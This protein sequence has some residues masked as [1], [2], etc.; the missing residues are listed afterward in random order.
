[1]A[2]VEPASTLFFIQRGKKALLKN[3]E[4]L[5]RRVVELET[6]NAQLKQNLLGS[7]DLFN[8]IFHASSNVMA[9]HTIQEG[10]F[11]DLNEACAKLGGFKR[12]ELIGHRMEEWDLLQDE[13]LKEI[14]AQK[15][16]DEGRI[17][18]VESKI[19]TKDG[20][21]RT[22]LFSADPVT[23]NSE[24]CLL[25]I[26]IDITERE[27]EASALRQSEEK[28]RSLVENSLQG[29][30]II[31]DSL[32]VFC[33]GNF[34][35]MLGCTVEEAL[36]L[37]AEQ[38]DALVFPDDSEAI[39][40]RHQDQLDGKPV[41]ARYEFRGF[42]LDGSMIWLEAYTSVIEFGGRP[43]IQSVYMDI[44]ER[45]NAENA[46]RESEERFRLLAETIDEIF[47]IFDMGGKGIAYLSPAY[48]RLWGYPRELVLMR[49]DPFMMEMVHVEDRDTVIANR[50]C[51]LSGR[52]VSFEYR[53]IRP[54]GSVRNMW[55]RAYPILDKGGNVFR[56]IGVGQDVTEWR[57][58]E[59]ALKEAK[60]YL[61]QIINC[62]GDPIFV[63]DREHRFV[64]V[65]DAICAFTGMKR[66]EM[67][68]HAG[69]PPEIEASLWRQEEHVFETRQETSTEDVFTDVQGNP[70]T[71]MTKKT[72]LTDKSGHEQIVGVLRDITEH[73]RLEAQFLQSQKMEAV[74]VLAGGVAHDFNNLLNV[75]NGYTELI[76]DGLAQGDPLRE[77][78]N[79]IRDAGQRA[80]ALT[81]Q[82]LD[83]GRKQL[84][85]PEIFDLNRVLSEMSA[86][87]RR[88]IGED[89]E[90]LFHPQSTPATIHADPAK[91]Q[92]VVMNLVIN[93]RDAMP[94][95]GK[96]TIETASVNFESGYISRHSVAKP[97]H[98]IMLA[99]SDTGAGMD[100]AIQAHVFEPFFTTKAKGKGTG[101]GLS[102]VYGIVKQSGGFI[103]VY[104]EPGKGTT[105]KTYFPKSEIMTAAPQTEAKP[106]IE[107]TGLETV[108]L[109]EDEAAVRSLTSRILRDRGYNVLEAADGME[110]LNISQEY[111]SEIHMV[112]TDVVMPGMGGKALVSRI[113]ELRPGVKTLFISGYTDNAIS[114]HGILDSGVAFLQKP[115]TLDGLVRKVR[116]VLDS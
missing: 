53:I 25:G 112:L 26:S 114:H 39:R 66:D 94:D 97:G 20:D 48:D 32:L 5:N 82:L 15:L 105:I 10:R 24:P 21:V 46:L 42:K 101:L 77:E 86:M 54:D 50:E 47:W 110:A 104:S 38:L 115:F 75:I 74:G 34:A 1:V 109:V 78:L 27:I 6:E 100:A 51:L 31:Q 90:I 40:Q 89:I 18:N 14:V 8:K 36:R 57:R 102:T 44:T 55:E 59:E 63:K 17:S 23:I 107:F 67:L 69:M 2:P 108:L 83:F 58:A 60:E 91:V 99:I 73:K 12:E 9:I 49:P 7:Q 95:G 71:M 4:D 29:L 113:G 87:L 30:T 56:T 92:Q 3:L 103:W 61:N 43:A 33:N 41:N 65:N 13:K 72:L 116:E 81:S 11:V 68:G 106:Q 64:L 22:V 19:R 37:S 85:Q 98:Y 70:R 93:A 84:L 80:A 16:R 52:A 62:I 88:M 79:Q 45:K 76:L 96:I 35:S 28:Y 111:K